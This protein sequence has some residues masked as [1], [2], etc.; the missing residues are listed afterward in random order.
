MRFHR[1]VSPAQY[2]H[3]ALP[4]LHSNF[5]AVMTVT[6]PTLPASVD[7]TCPGSNW[8]AYGDAC[9]LFQP[10]TWL[11]ADEARGDCLEFGGQLATIRNVY[12]NLFVQ[13]QLSL[14]SKLPFSRRHWIGLERAA[15]GYPR[16][17]I[18]LRYFLLS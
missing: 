17:D 14:A 5:D 1:S 18:N 6:R 8:T 9:F 10:D 12:E 4:H 3:C 7:G 2:K 15:G 16:D 11:T 13:T